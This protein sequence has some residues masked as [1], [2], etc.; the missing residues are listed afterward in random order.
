M[1]AR[2]YSHAHKHAQS[3][4]WCQVS[5]LIPLYLTS[6]TEPLSGHELPGS[7]RPAGHLILGS[8]VS[9]PSTRIVCTCLHVRH[10][11]VGSNNV[12]LVILL[13]QHHF[14]AWASAQ[15]LARGGEDGLAGMAVMTRELREAF[16]K[17][18]QGML[19]SRECWQSWLAALG[20]P[21]TQMPLFYGVPANWIN[22]KEKILSKFMLNFNN[23]YQSTST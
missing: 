11:F 20:A 16:F 18:W 23:L 6:E 21:P 9:L 13:L 14:P 19:R 1:C 7:T 22:E 4:G 8:T 3:R 15:L 17:N 12:S 10:F 2:V 5:P